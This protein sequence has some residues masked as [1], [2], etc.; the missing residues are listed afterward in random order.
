MVAF[1][2]LPV[3]VVTLSTVRQLFLFLP[4]NKV[5]STVSR[6]GTG[7]TAV[8][9][10][11]TGASAC[12]LL[13]KCTLVQALR[14]CTGRTAHR[15]MRGIALLFLDHGT[16]RWCEVSVTPRPLFTTGKDPGTHCT[17]GWVGPRAGLDRCGKSR[18]HRDSIPNRPAH[19]QSLYRLSYPAHCV[20]LYC[21]IIM[22]Q[23][24]YHQVQSCLNTK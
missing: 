14:P 8:R 7:K 20:L 12:V 19:S 2:W 16:R 23:R 18:L 24:Y 10:W 21:N 1:D 9:C 22:L 13:L 11:R 6:S 4:C 5:F 3:G 15:G 17:G